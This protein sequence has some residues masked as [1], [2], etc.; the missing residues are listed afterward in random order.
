MADL[1]LS[2]LKDDTNITKGQPAQWEGKGDNTFRYVAD[3]LDYQA[4]GAIKSVSSVPTMWARPLITEMAL[5]DT[6]HPIHQVMVAQ[7]R[8]M[9]AAIALAEVEGFNL[10]VQFLDLS[11]QRFQPFGDA[12]FQLMPEPIN[13][14]Y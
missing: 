5:Y 2:K 1:L 8:G 3:S 7:W 13:A 11:T 10:K 6:K 14:L 4:P 12:L 9:M